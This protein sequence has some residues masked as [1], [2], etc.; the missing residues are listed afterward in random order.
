MEITTSPTTVRQER[1]ATAALAKLP[2]VRPALGAS[3]QDQR[4]PSLAPYGR[5][6]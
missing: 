6:L 3:V 1:R 2:V 5:R 4:A